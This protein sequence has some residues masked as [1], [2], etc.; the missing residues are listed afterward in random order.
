M[1]TIIERIIFKG[2]IQRPVLAA[3]KTMTTLDITE[4]IAAMTMIFLL[5]VN[6][7]KSG[8]WGQNLQESL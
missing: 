6:F 3:T 7:W 2:G 5:H 1:P 4:T 8:I